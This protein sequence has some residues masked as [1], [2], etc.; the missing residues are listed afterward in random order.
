MFKLNLL[1][2]FFLKDLIFNNAFFL[3]AIFI[4][5]T[6]FGSE[7]FYIVV[8]PPVYWCINKKFGFRLMVITTLAA[9]V[10]TAIKNIIKL[11]RP[12]AYLWKTTPESYSFPSGHAFGSTTLWLYTM[13]FTRRKFYI[14]LGVVMIVLVA[15]SRIYLG[16]HYPGDVLAGVALGICTIALFLVF[17]P[18]LT[19]VIKTWSL[20]RK[21]IM[22]TIPPVLL[23]LFS[24]I[25]FTTDDRGVRL[26]GALLGVILGYI[27]E[28]E[29]VR[30]TVDVPF[31]VKITRIILGL[32]I[33]FMAYFGLSTALP[34][35]ITTSLFTAWFGGFSVMFI[36]PFRHPD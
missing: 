6:G 21:I 14:I 28:N 33:A 22:G 3:D 31:R 13:V 23:F 2:V 8:I 12:P 17:E 35:N 29:Y 15:I 32:F 4:I 1:T 5:I 16:V 18:K 24:S 11:P 26:A 20:D 9:Y 36:A 10:A 19:R 34:Y 7:I 27:L 25:F 30:F